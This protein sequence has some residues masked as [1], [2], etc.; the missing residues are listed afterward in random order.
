MVGK[1]KTL[2]DYKK[3]ADKYG[4]KFIPTDRP[5]NIETKIEG[6]LCENNHLVTKSYKD[7][8]QHGFKCISCKNILILE[9]RSQAILDS[10]N[11]NHPELP[12][13]INQRIDKT[14]YIYK[15]R[16]RYWENNKLK[17][18][19]FK[20]PSECEDCKNADIKYTKKQTLQDYHN[21]AENNQLICLLN[22][23]KDLPKYSHHSSKKNMWKCKKCD[24]EWKC[25]YDSIRE[26]TNCRKC[27]HASLR[28]Y[29]M[30]DYHKLV[31]NTNL[32]CLIN[33]EKDVPKNVSNSVD[34]FIW[35]CKV[36]G[37]QFSSCYTDMKRNKKLCPKCS[38]HTKKQLKDYHDI[39]K[40]RSIICLLNNMD[41]IPDD[42]TI[43]PNEPI[44]QCKD[45]EYKFS[46][47][48]TII[49]KGSGCP[50]CYKIIL[51]DYYIMAKKHN[52]IYILNEPAE[53]VTI[54]I[55]GWQCKKS[56]IS[57]K[58]YQQI[59]Q[60]GFKCEYCQDGSSLEQKIQTILESRN[61]IFER[62]YKLSTHKK[63]SYD[64]FISPNYL[65]ECDGG[66][67]FEETK[68]FSMTLKEQQQRDILKTNLAI[69]NGFKLLR[70]DYEFILK[71]DIETIW[72]MLQMFFTFGKSNINCLFSS[73]KYNHIIDLL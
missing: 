51:K 12:K 4:I 33:D 50:N 44:W 67:H 63:L 58:S 52:I 24:H 54:K 18:G 68:F 71:S 65:I 61:V 64:L 38:G 32:I 31:E 62:Q 21:L 13:L 72:D 17:C 40:D 59:R 36:C 37:Y 9:Q 66:Q 45:C 39:V 11:I 25:R 2:E 55:R 30:E 49:Q 43:S 20:E 1:P 53:N 57:Y 5:K 46:T 28:K 70:M 27:F 7:I 6:W 16:K 42:T 8:Y 47:S 22:D 15:G 56:H 26:G 69:E 48:Y 34:I 23:E 3:L 10:K 60:N 41:K 73:T 29:K 14:W 19:H 35:Q